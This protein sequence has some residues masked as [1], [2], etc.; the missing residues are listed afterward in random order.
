VPKPLLVALSTAKHSLQRKFPQRDRVSIMISRF[1]CY[2]C[3][4][5]LSYRCL[6]SLRV[7]MLP[8]PGTLLLEREESI[9]VPMLAVIFAW[10]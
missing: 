3:M 8:G 5:Q 2:S 4:V 9:V 6:S 1:I 7:H 10:L